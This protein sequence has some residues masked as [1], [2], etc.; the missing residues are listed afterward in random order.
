MSVSASWR[1]A[2]FLAWQQ[3]RYERWRTAALAGAL[4]LLTALPLATWLGGDVVERSLLSRAD[5]TPILVGAPGNDYELTLASLYFRTRPQTT[6]PV[7]VVDEL[8]RQIQG[9]VVPVYMAHSAQGVPLVATTAAYFGAREMTLAQGRPALQIGEIVVGSAVARRFSYT[10]GGQLRNDL[11]NLYNLA[12]AYPFLLRIVGILAPTQGPDDHAIFTNLKTAWTLD[13]KM[14]GHEAVD[15][16]SEALAPGEERAA[17]D[18]VEASAA[19]FLFS[20]LTSAN[21]ST[22]HL[23]GEADLAPVSAVLLFPADRREHDI[24]LGHL[25]LRTDLQAIRPSRVLE[26]LVSLVLRLRRVLDAY[27]VS[28]ALAT[29]LLVALLAV[30]TVRQ[31]REELQLLTDLG[32]SRRRIGTI[33]LAELGLV[34]LLAAAPS[35]ALVSGVVV[36]GRRLLLG[37]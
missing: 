11:Q 32:A 15:L 14:H 29:T 7:R 6:L 17:D 13:G 27:V 35:A 24:A 26:T 25:A 2:V 37:M 19:L 16:D 3:A 8:S 18:I 4:C 28:V 22:F 21:Q 34:A 30:L 10:V 20:E 23:H 36:W 5:A 1:H 12:G 9:A 33:L 31:R